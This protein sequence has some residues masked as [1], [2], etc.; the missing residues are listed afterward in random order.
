MTDKTSEQFLL[1]KAGKSFRFDNFLFKKQKECAK[2]LYQINK[3]P[4]GDR[5]REKAFSKLFAKFGQN[6]I[7]KEGF[8]CNFGFNISMGDNCYLNYDVKFLDTYPIEIGNNVFI[9]PNA[10]V[11]AVTHPLVAK[12][13][14]NLQGG[15]VKI[16]DDVWIGANATILPNITLGRGC[17]VAAGAVVTKDVAPNTVVGGIPAKFI[18]NVNN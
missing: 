7:I 9:A 10:V 16:E 18:K 6:N 2:I 5:H 1:M 4:F 8:R 11:S 12:E 17:V 15:T 14:R 3:L 13:R